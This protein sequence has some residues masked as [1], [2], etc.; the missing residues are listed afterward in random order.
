MERLGAVGI[1]WAIGTGGVLMLLDSDKTA[2]MLEKSLGVS[3]L[4]YK[5]IANN[6]ANLDTP[7]FKKSYVD[8]EDI[9]KSA[10]GSQA[11]PDKIQAVEPK[12]Q[13]ETLS[14]LRVDGNNVDLEEEMTQLVMNTLNY[15]FSAQQ[16]NKKLAMLKY[17]ILDGR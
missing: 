13:R 3:A 2:V 9:L 10:I 4:R 17:V 7:G 6:I 11:N 14:S 8:F 16:I 5:V 1:T 12:V 15:N